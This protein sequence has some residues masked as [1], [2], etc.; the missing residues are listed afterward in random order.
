[1]PENRDSG[2]NST[3]R[4]E[5]STARTRRAGRTRFVVRVLA[6]PDAGQ[7]IAIT[8]ADPSAVLVGQSPTCGLRLTDGQTS[9]RHLALEVAGDR[10]SVRDLDSTNGTF[11]NGLQVTGALLQGGERIE[12]GQTTLVVERSDDDT[13]TKL[14]GKYR[15]GPLLGAS[16]AMRRLYPLCN[17]LAASD[18]PVI[19]EGETGTGKEVLAEALHQLGSRKDRPFV[20]FDCTCVPASLME[21]ALFGHERGA[22]TG[23]TESRPGVFEA[24]DG[25]TL[26]IDE[27][28]DLEIGLQAKLLRVLERMQIAR[29]GSTRYRRVNVRVLAATRRDLDAEIQANRFRDD[30]Y[31][32]LAVARVEL[33]PLRRRKGD[34]ALL[35]TQFWRDLGGGEG[36]VP[37]DVLKRLEAYSWP[38][39][40]RELRN[41]IARQVALGELGESALPTYKGDADGAI[42]ETAVTSVEI[43]PPFEPLENDS[44]AAS[45]APDQVGLRRD[46]VVDRVL[47][48]E[49]PLTE[50][51]QLLLREFEQ[52]YVQRMLLAHG[53]NV[54]RAAVAAGVARRYFQILQARGRTRGSGETE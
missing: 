44:G 2:Q 35:A 52:R 21:S 40:V 1:M 34:I 28:G 43:Q 30:L 12:I 54:R 5:R 47:S 8:P 14:D 33:P 39:N 17:L 41:A 25:G 13:K 22:F 6:G 20:V 51:K 11:V 46:E 29:V 27:I 7:S 15:F 53:G 32:R 37:S 19:I 24:A 31:F 9:R 16:P 49:L 4:I 26:L 23:A 36:G 45:E 38:G 48:L 18:V 3:V 50:A 10:L 42:V